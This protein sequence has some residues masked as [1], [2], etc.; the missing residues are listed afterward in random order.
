M[1]DVVRRGLPPRRRRRDRTLR[2]STPPGM[3]SGD[4]LKGGGPERPSQQPAPAKAP[5]PKGTSKDALWG[6]LG[7]VVVGVVLVAIVG[8][9]VGGDEPKGPVPDVVGMKLE[10]AKQSLDAAGYGADEDDQSDSLDFNTDNNVVCSTSPKAGEKAGG[11]VTLVL[12]SNA[13]K[14]GGGVAQAEKASKPKPAPFVAEDSAV[15]SLFEEEMGADPEFGDSRV[16]ESACNRITCTVQYNADTPVFNAEKEL[17]N[18]MRPIFKE[19]F[20]D[21]RLKLA[22]LVPYGETTSVGGKKSVSPVM[23]ISCDRAANQQID[24]DSV[25][26]K[27]MK[28]LCEYTALVGFE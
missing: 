19:L 3:S 23:R 11:D 28:V 22:K 8:A 15:V 25:D 4:P 13:Q 10:D 1:L 20:R 9:L 18:N 21:K 7:L 12:K 6:C 26:H 5:P 14:C 17:L 24:W 2:V 27:G 16:R